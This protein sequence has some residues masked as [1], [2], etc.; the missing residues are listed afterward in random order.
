MLFIDAL[1][2]GLRAAWIAGKSRPSS[3]PMTATDANCD[4]T[5]CAGSVRKTISRPPGSRPKRACWR[6]S[7]I[8]RC[9]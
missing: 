8:I 6:P 7:S 2:R 1:R 4:W 5:G 3:T 9:M